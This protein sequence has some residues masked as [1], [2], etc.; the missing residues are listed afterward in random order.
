MF[1]HCRHGWRC[2]TRGPWRGWRRRGLREEGGMSHGLIHSLPIINEG[3]CRRGRRESCGHRIPVVGIRHRGGMEVRVSMEMLLTLSLKPHAKELSLG[4]KGSAGEE[5]TAHEHECVVVAHG[6]RER[7]AGLTFR[8]VAGVEHLADLLQNLQSRVFMGF[9]QLHVVGAHAELKQ[10]ER[11]FTH[12]PLEHTSAT[13]Y[14]RHLPARRLRWRRR[15]RHA[16]RDDHGPWRA[17]AGTRRLHGNSKIY[18]ANIKVGKVSL[19]QV[20]IQS[21]VAIA[22]NKRNKHNHNPQSIY[23]LHEQKC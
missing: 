21:P 8:Q 12:R 3:P 2:R 22:Q 15:G 23:K 6:Q 11:G 13:A 17:T 16:H 1:G 5:E 14:R 19:V 18:C 4:M 20:H 9:R 7:L 10:R